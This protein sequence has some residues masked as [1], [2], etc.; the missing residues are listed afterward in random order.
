MKSTFLEQ[1]EAKGFVLLN[2]YKAARAR[3]RTSVPEIIA[4]IGRAATRRLAA[5]TRE[6]DI[7]RG[8]AEESQNA[9]SGAVG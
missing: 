1:N 7:G 2:P 3:A 8:H 5:V 9:G 6:A 4:V